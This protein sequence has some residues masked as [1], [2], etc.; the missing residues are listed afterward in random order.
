MRILCFGIL[1]ACFIINCTQES[2]P[3][4]DTSD[5]KAYYLIERGYK[6][7]LH[8]SVPETVASWKRK[9]TI[10]DVGITL[11]GDK[12]NDAPLKS[13][14]NIDIEI[15]EEPSSVQYSSDIFIQFMDEPKN[16]LF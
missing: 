14:Q 11:W 9:I 12:C 4:H 5:A 13:L 16:E 8:S 6:C 1:I 3:E 15:I 10:D 2:I 7:K